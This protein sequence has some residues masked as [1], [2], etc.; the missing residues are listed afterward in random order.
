MET[1]TKYFGT[2]PYTEDEVITFKNG[3]FGFEENKK[4]LLIRFED[5][6]AGILCLQNLEDAQLAFIV[7]N[8][9][10]F[11]PDYAP[12]VSTADLKKIGSPAPSRSH[13]IQPAFCRRIWQ[14]APQT[15]AVLW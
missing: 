1:N 14:K 3:I 5:D 15:C 8:P 2:M 13:S 7:A 11:L 6:N 9:F 12:Q 4:Y 10:V